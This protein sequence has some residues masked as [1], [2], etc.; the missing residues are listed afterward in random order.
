MLDDRR[1]VTAAAAMGEVA[2]GRVGERASIAA[3][4]GGL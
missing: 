2:R 4:A 1:Q 3:D